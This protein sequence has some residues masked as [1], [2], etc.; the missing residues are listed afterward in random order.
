MNASSGKTP[1]QNGN[2]GGQRADAWTALAYMLSG[3]LF[4]GLAG[5]GLDE[6]LGTILFLPL[7]LV[8]GGAA[9][10]YLVYVRYVKS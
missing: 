7:G 2:G 6:W 4:Y 1:D 10:V 3:P 5:W 9:S 8:G